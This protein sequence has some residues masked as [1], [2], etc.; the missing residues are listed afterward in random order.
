[1]HNPIKKNTPK[2]DGYIDQ[3]F[4]CSCKCINNRG[5]NIEIYSWNHCCYWCCLIASQIMF[6]FIHITRH[7]LTGYF[8]RH[9]WGVF[10]KAG[11]VMFV[12]PGKRETLGCPFHKGRFQPLTQTWVRGLTPSCFRK[13]GN[14]KSESLIVGACE[15]QK[16]EMLYELRIH[17]ARIL[18]VDYFY[19]KKRKKKSVQL[20]WMNNLI[21]S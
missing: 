21:I 8:I 3:I 16:P 6:Q 15:L 18:E 20:F 2:Q 14:L 11:L 12:N 13:T 7:T 19:L 1:M 10:Q 4:K 5:Q 17:S 9:I